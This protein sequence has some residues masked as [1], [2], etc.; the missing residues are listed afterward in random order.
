M[1]EQLIQIVNE[2]DQP[3][4]G[5]TMDEVQ[6]TPGG[7]WHRI[8]RVVCTDGSGNYLLQKRGQN[9]FSYPGCW[10]TTASGH[11]DLGESYRQA[12]QREAMEEIGLQGR[13]LA[14]VLYFQTERTGEDGRVYKRFNKIYEVI[15]AAHAIL[16]PNPKEVEE[17]RWFNKE[18]I[19]HMSERDPAQMAD[20]LLEYTERRLRA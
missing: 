10:D 3:L 19:L 5:G 16:T 11:V 18:D 14:Q 6:L 20:G 8:A 17:L 13:S 15:V 9:E 2:W 12:A 4:R 1:G 7:L